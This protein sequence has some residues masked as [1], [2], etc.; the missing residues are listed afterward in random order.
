MTGD[1]TQLQ[2]WQAVVLGLVEG[3]TEYL[4]ISSTGHLILA[5]QFMK[6]N[7][8]DQQKQ[9]VDDFCIVIQ[10]GAIAA[11]IGLYWPRI[12]QMLKGCVGRSEAGLKLL[13]NL[14]IAF[15]PSAVIGLLLGDTINAHLFQEGP[16]LFALA[17]GA[18]YMII[19]DLKAQG[20]I[21]RY[22][23]PVQGPGIDDIT[24]KQALM[25]G[26]LQC[27]ALWPGTSRSM[28]T[29]TGGIFAGLKPRQA[30]EFSFLLGLPTLVAATI[31]KL[32]KNLYKSH[33]DH[34]P[35]MFET[36]GYAA[37]AVGIVVA[38]VSAALAVKWL[39]SF[40]TR[41]G[42]TPFGWY[43]LA[44]CA[45]LGGMILSGTLTID[46]TPKKTIQRQTEVADPI[47]WPANNGLPNH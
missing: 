46:P 33:K 31:Y 39:V 2:L 25:I 34:V 37:C 6:L 11:V 44:L 28:M 32:G 13:F 26:F 45:L 42:L 35:N 5:S 47:K 29:I 30:A 17:A 23:Q 15:L 21:G 4:P 7:H 8:T 20:R 40:L 24:P 12:V 22:P 41:R 9:A 18:V 27:F 38:A 3:I 1:P 19:M 36:L 16:V 14:F 43:R 10:S